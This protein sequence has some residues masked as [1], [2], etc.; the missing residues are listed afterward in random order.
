MKVFF[1]LDPICSAY[2]NVK[3]DMIGG[4][5]RY[6]NIL[7]RYLRSVGVK[8]IVNPELESS[9]IYDV[10]IHS[11]VKNKNVI[12][13]KHVCRAGS[14]HTDAMKEHYDLVI[15]ISKYF[16]DYIKNPNTLV[17]PACYDK[18]LD[19]FYSSDYEDR[20][21][22]TVSNPNRHYSHACL[23]ADL[24]EA[25]NVSFKWEICGG[26]KIYSWDYNEMYDF[27]S[28]QNISYLGVLSHKDTL[29][30]LSTSHIS[31]Y[32]SFSDGSETF[33][34]ANIESLALGVPVILPRK[35]PFTEVI[36]D[37]PYFC[38]SVEE[39]A[40]LIENLLTV[41]RKDLICH[42]VSRYS[43]DV[44]MPKVY[45]SLINLF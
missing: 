7:A 5:E 4:T 16:A 12:A 6:F 18:E 13:R 34:I 37:N 8:V 32:P 19:Y 15:C 42:D 10:A 31:C 35:L 44:V 11:N 30:K 27:T 29:K 17:I 36:P 9:Q 22:I 2:K 39:M 41:N 20:R 28:N 14:L 38:D 26:N 24:L 45:K 21:I 40:D 25:K 43:E 23:V 33:C 3:D 1:A